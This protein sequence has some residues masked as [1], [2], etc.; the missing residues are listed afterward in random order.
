MSPELL[1]PVMF[2]LKDSRPTKGSD[3]YA[4][5]MVVYEILSRQA[6]FP[7]CMDAVV[8]LKVMSGEC[9]V[10]PEGAQG[11]WFRDGLWE[12]LELCWKPRR[13]DRPSLNVLLQYL[14]G[15]T[16]PSRPPSPTPT[17]NEDAETDTSGF[18]VTDPGTFPVH[19]LSWPTF[20]CP[21]VVGPTVGPS[22]D[23]FP[24]PPRNVPRSM[25]QG[26]G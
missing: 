4:L 21:H 16:P 10:R 11:A 19:P 26:E 24:V 3:I 14:E 22:A 25:V 5:G 18:T 2:G 8:I 20:N 17:V 13:D 6:P 9:P 23:Q 7:R 1:N 15:A 12:I